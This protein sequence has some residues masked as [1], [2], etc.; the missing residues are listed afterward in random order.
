MPITRKQFEI[1]ID[2][3]IEEW[4]YKI[5]TFLVV[6]KDEAFTEG[7]LWEKIYGKSGWRVVVR[8]AF[9]EALGKLVDTGGARKRKIRDVE[10]YIHEVPF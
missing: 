6:H 4:M 9:E 5:S 2:A 1:G 3:E 10:Y 7:E 8:E